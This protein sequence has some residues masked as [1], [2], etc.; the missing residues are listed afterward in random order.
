MRFPIKVTDNGVS[1]LIISQV[2]KGKKKKKTTEIIKRYHEGKSTN[3][4]SNNFNF[5]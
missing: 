4:N 3:E 5:H 2:S 1:I